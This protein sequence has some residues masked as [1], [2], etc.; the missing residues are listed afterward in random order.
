MD[1]DMGP[2]KALNRGAMLPTS[3]REEEKLHYW[4]REEN[5][6]PQLSLKIKHRLEANA[7]HREIKWALR[8]SKKM[9]KARFGEMAERKKIFSWTGKTENRMNEYPWT[10]RAALGK[11]SGYTAKIERPL[12]LLSWSWLK[13]WARL[14]KIYEAEYLE[15][16]LVFIFSE[17]IEH[18]RYTYR[19]ICVYANIAI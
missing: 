10:L 6:Y 2:T 4:T 3:R 8:T 13:S 18:V 7:N 11:I 12:S 14:I 9:P 5:I 1:S 15:E 17:Y 16:V 19:W